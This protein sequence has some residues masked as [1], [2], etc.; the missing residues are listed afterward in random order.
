MVFLDYHESSKSLYTLDGFTGNLRVY[1]LDVNALSTAEPVRMGG[2]VH[3]DQFANEAFIQS[4]DDKAREGGFSHFISILLWDGFSVD[5]EGSV[6]VNESSDSKRG[7]MTFVEYGANSIV[8]E[9]HIFQN[10][11]CCSNRFVVWRDCAVI[12]TDPLAPINQ[13]NTVRSMP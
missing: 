7:T 10:L 12:Y 5:D 3:P 2:K 1:S 4:Q 13:C 11:D 6:W 9:S 8:P